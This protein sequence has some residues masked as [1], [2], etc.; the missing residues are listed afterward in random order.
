M[1]MDQPDIAAYQ[2]LF[3][4]YGDNM[5]DAYLQ[6]DDERYRLLFDQICRMLVKPSTTNLRLPEPFRHTAMLYLAEDADTLAHMRDPANRNF[7]ISDL[8]DFLHLLARSSAG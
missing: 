6:P 1:N 7:M 4:L 3:R 2:E 8:A 5:G